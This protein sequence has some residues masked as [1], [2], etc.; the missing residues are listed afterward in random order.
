MIKNV[1]VNKVIIQ[2]SM[3]ICIV[4]SIFTIIKYIIKGCCLDSFAAFCS[5]L[6][7]F[8]PPALLHIYKLGHKKMVM[9]IHVI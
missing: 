7:R 8:L 4:D 9:I 1:V 2:F 5:G 6:F 3:Q